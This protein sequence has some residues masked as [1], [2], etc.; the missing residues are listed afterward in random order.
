MLLEYNY[1]KGNL[2]LEMLKKSEIATLTISQV[3]T[4]DNTS[5][6]VMDY[7]L[8]SDY[9]EPK[10]NVIRKALA[11]SLPERLQMVNVLNGFIEQQILNNVNSFSLKFNS[12]NVRKCQI[13][14]QTSYKSSKSS[15]S[16]LNL[17]P[18]L[19]NVLERYEHI[20]TKMG[21]MDQQTNVFKKEA[22]GKGKKYTPLTIGEVSKA[23]RQSLMEG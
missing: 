15:E 19:I 11:E 10:Q 4:G 22:G 12:V 7:T 23:L 1:D 21:I 17:L 16:N 5:A 20:A 6:F 9:P 3:E 2:V 8:V 14:Y 18:E 13:S